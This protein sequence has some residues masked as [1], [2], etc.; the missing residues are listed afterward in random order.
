MERSIMDAAKKT[1][2]QR[3]AEVIKFFRDERKL[4]LARAANMAEVNVASFADFEEGNTI[5]DQRTWERMKHIV[6][7]GLKAH[8]DLW[9]QAR[10]EEATEQAQKVAGKGLTQKPF[11]ALAQL[12]LV[13]DPPP[14]P[15]PPPPEPSRAPGI[16]EALVGD[17][18]DLQPAYVALNQLPKGWQG[19]LASQ[20]R[21]EYAR[22]LVAQG[23]STKDVI[24]KVRE[25]FRVGILDATVAAIRE[26]LGVVAVRKT[27]APASTTAT[28]PIRRPAAPPTE[29]APVTPT[30]PPEVV[31][32]VA[33]TVAP[34]E[35]REEFARIILR[36]SPTVQTDVLEGILQR[37][38]G[39]GLPP[40]RMAT[41]RAEVK[42]ARTGIQGTVVPAMPV[43]ERDIQAAVEMLL[44]AMPH[45]KSFTVN[46]D[47][48]GEVKID[49][50]VK[51]TRVVEASSTLKIRR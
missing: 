49:Y 13:P 11:A 51:E 14:A 44:E 34:L 18:Y 19:K 39:A 9:R 30:L 29:A 42:A 17:G 12:K 45:L 21:V 7:H 37:K 1:A 46:I 33:P 40:D 4:T 6:H 25:R 36:K 27:P 20:E 8:E 35:E 22:E 26:E 31:P 28:G 47:D 15:P 32:P 50:T 43:N 38:F 48:A 41:L 2:R 10:T 23:L 3:L 16:P 24:A 5:P